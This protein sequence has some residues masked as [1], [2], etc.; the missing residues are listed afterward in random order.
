MGSL[1]G[2]DQSNSVY[3][4]VILV[5]VVDRSGHWDI[6]SEVCRYDGWNNLVR[7]FQDDVECHP[8]VKAKS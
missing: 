4:L 8:W 3:F 1:L 5:I 6:V 2:D 7:C